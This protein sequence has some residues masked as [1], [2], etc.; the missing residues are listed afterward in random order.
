MGCD[1][2]GCIEYNYNKR[3]RHRE[4]E[5]NPIWEFLMDTNMFMDRNYKLFGDL[6]GVRKYDEDPT[7]IGERGIP[8]DWKE[9]PD[10]T[11]AEEH[12]GFKDWIEGNVDWHSPSWALWGELKGYFSTSNSS[13]QQLGNDW[14]MLADLMRLFARRYGENDI[15]LV[16]W[17]DN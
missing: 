11:K 16:V 6:F 15:R 14:L 8:D 4:K 2:H 17:F 12:D 3:W 13:Y 5:K 7:I 9:G 10:D 1:I